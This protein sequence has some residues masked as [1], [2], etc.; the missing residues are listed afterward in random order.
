MLPWV[1]HTNEMYRKFLHHHI[2]KLGRLLVIFAV[3]P[4]R[5]VWGEFVF[6]PTALYTI[7]LLKN[8]AI[9]FPLVS[10]TNEMLFES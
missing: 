1:N 7:H 9:L 8:T 6:T 5:F 4:M 2:Q 3:W 10:Y